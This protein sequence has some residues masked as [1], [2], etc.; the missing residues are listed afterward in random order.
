[1]LVAD[2][3]GGLIKI[4]F[5]NGDQIIGRDPVKKEDENRDA[6]GQFASIPDRPGTVPIPE[7]HVRLYH[8]T[9][10]DNVAS[11][12]KE[13]LTYSHA[14]GIEGPKAIYA[15]ETGFYGKPGKV[16]TIEF[17]V[18]KDQWESGT[19]VT[20]DVPPENIIAVHLPWHD[21]ARYLEDNPESKAQ[22]LAGEYDTLTGDYAKGVAYIKQKYGVAKDD[23]PRSPNGEFASGSGGQVYR[24]INLA[25]VLLT[26]RD[27]YNA[28]AVKVRNS[29]CD[30]TTLTAD[31]KQS[32][33]Y[34]GGMG[35]SPMNRG[36]RDPTTDTGQHKQDIQQ[37]DTAIQKGRLPE[38]LVLYR[39]VGNWQK[40]FGVD[41]EDQLLGKT[42]QDNGFIST[43]T[44]VEKASNFSNHESEGGRTLV[45]IHAPKD[46]HAVAMPFFTSENE[47]LLPRG[48]QF[49]VTAV[50]HTEL[51]FPLSFNA[52]LSA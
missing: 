9:G 27:D 41:S 4:L 29:I 26:H 6:K 35:F 49:K 14:K 5:P 51:H 15:S 8:Q 3:P 12:L 47:V 1:M 36:L 28:A 48:T 20:Q 11:I 18:P 24:Q 34:Y 52:C 40:A 33:A 39:G 45:E 16:P 19:F 23:Q 31:E 25:Q 46:M 43:T 32:L 2:L 44:D 50:E 37:I 42:V 10:E 30:P 7:G 21:K 22:A 13:G 38:N 17:H